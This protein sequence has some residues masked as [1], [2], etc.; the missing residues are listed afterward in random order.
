MARYFEFSG[1]SIDFPTRADFS[2][3]IEYFND[4]V[5]GGGRDRTVYGVIRITPQITVAYDVNGLKFTQYVLGSISPDSKTI[6]V[7]STV[8]ESFYKV[9]TEEGTMSLHNAKVDT[10]ELTIEEG[11]PVR[12]EFTAIGKT[13]G[14]EAASAYQ[15]DFDSMALVPSDC[16]LKINN[17]VNPNWTRITCRISNALD[18]IFKTSSIPVNIRETGLEITGVLRAPHYYQWANEG[19]V[20]IILGNVGTI[21][22]PK[23]R[24]TEIP[25]RVTGFDVPETEISYRAYP[26]STQDA[27]KIFLSNTIK[28]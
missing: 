17:T 1:G 26:T 4:F 20:D 11:A 13:I 8:P 10:W 15:P 21:T 2:K 23:V 5:L 24:F 3:R 18:V 19:S 9:S 7:A 16:T 12:A 25:P 28:W 27:I 6:S 22:M 14:A